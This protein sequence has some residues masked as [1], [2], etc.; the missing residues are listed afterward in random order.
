M[1]TSIISVIEPISVRV[2]E[3][4]NLDILSINGYDFTDHN[5]EMEVHRGSPDKDP[6]LSFALGD[7]ITVSGTSIIFTKTAAQMQIV[8]KNYTYYIW[9]T[10]PGGDRKVWINGDF[11]ANALPSSGIP[12]TKKLTVYSEG[13]SIA[14]NVRLL[15]NIN[16]ELQPNAN[17]I[18]VNSKLDLPNPENGIIILGDNVTYM[19]TNIVDLQGDRLICGQ[20]TVLLG[21]SSENCRIKSI[22]LDSNTAL[23]TTKWSLPIRNITL[24]HDTVLDLDASGNPNQSLDWFGVNFE[25]CNTIGL[26]RSYNNFIASDCAILNSANWTFDGTIGTVG[27]SQCIFDG[28]ESQ[29][30]I[31]F[32]STLTITRRI[33]FISCPFIVLPGEIGINLDPSAIIPIEGF[34]SHFSDYSGGGTYL[35]GV[36]STSNKSLFSDNKGVKNSDAISYYTMTGNN[37]PT[38]ILQAANPYKIIGTTISQ[39][40]TQKFNN[41]DNK[42]EYSGEVTRNFKISVILSLISGNNHQIG[43]YIAKNGN[44]IENFEPYVTTNGAGKAENVTTQEVVELSYGD[45]IEIFIEN[46]TNPTD[47]TVQELSVIIEALN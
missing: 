30:T 32:P 2:G 26:I 4:F 13:Q 27:F 44:V 33:R 46:N 24:E 17:F 42:S 37:T 11:F 1:A 45:F 20:N 7:G 9:I 12:Q 25:N 8:P 15:E 14:L 10:P 16:I 18:F 31:I 6:I 28:R 21:G 36:L 35:G 19:F 5:V 34:K 43:T 47:I 3:A 41:T 38:I 29:T 22:G 23:I 39:P 40:I